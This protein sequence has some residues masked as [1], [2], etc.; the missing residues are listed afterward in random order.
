MKILKVLKIAWIVAIGFASFATAQT[1]TVLHDFTGQ[2]NRSLPYG[3][4]ILSGGVLYG[5]T[6]GGG[7]GNTGTVFKINPKGTGKSTLHSFAA[8]A[9][10]GPTNTD[11]AK[12]Y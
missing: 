1:T 7:T 6:S 5:T 10:S 11:G 3:G 4:L 2:D 12:P 9:S 8:F